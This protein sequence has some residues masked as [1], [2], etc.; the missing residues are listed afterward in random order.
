MK[1]RLAKDASRELES[2][3]QGAF[4]FSSIKVLSAMTV[5]LESL[6]IF[7]SRFATRTGIDLMVIASNARTG[8]PLWLLGSFSETAALIA[9][10]PIL[11]IKPH[12]EVQDFAPVPHLVVGVDTSVPVPAAALRWI[13]GTAKSM[14]A[15][16]DLIHVKPRKRLMDSMAPRPKKESPELILQGLQ[17]KFLKAGVSTHVLIKDEVES[18]A[19]TLVDCAEQK[20]AWVILTVVAKRSSVRK[21]LL[22]SDARRILSLTRRPFLSLRLE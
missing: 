16:L 11:I 21:L 7:I 20:Q 13:A 19:Q 2:S 9:P 5:D 10:M 15:E 18:V 17:R 3:L 8:L 4:R 22:G 14:G 6:V 1:G 12:I